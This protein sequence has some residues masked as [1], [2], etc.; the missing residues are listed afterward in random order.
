MEISSTVWPQRSICHYLQKEPNVHRSLLLYDAE[1]Y[2]TVKGVE[3]YDP[4]ISSL[5]YLVTFL[6]NCSITELL[7]PSHLPRS[8]NPVLP[9][10]SLEA[11][12]MAI[13]WDSCTL[14]MVSKCEVVL[15]HWLVILHVVCVL[16]F[17]DVHGTCYWFYRSKHLVHFPV[18]SWNMTLGSGTPALLP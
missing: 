4:R 7:F 15:Q 18:V 14:W 2:Y 17:K 11:L 12:G 16:G 6:T 1:C 8:H 5:E 3:L 9:K 13:G 10:T